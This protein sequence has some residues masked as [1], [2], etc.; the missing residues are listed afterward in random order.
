M[1]GRNLE[2]A[3]V[4]TWFCLKK[5]IFFDKPASLAGLEEIAR[6]H[7]AVVKLSR[8]FKLIR[9]GRMGVALNS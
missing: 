9:L 7:G 2:A 5:H 6:E 3:Q 4:V 8:L 1:F